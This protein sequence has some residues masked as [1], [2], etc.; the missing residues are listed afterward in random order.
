MIIT[1]TTDFG[2]ADP[3]VGM[4]KGVILS[5]APNAQLVDVTH[6]IRSYDILEAALIIEGSYRYFPRG[7]V[8]VIVVDPGVG[9]ERRPMAAT[10]NGHIF[11]APDNGVLSLVLHTDPAT[12]L[13]PAYQITNNSLFHG[14]VSRTF[15]GR[16]IFAPVAAHLAR[17]TPV[18]SVGPRIVDF[19]KKQIPLPRPQGDRL[20][21]TVLRIDKFGNIVTNFRRENLG[22]EF[23]IRIAGLSIT[24]LCGSFSE[25]DPGDFVAIEGSTGFI[26]LALNQGSAAERLGVER[27]AEIE[28]ETGSPNQ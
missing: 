21:G 28:L 6:E 12:S 17:G 5:I 15:H 10:A 13:T 27:G 25:A 16:D 26:E 3:F 4:M 11:V 1:L 24:R 14:P 23:S 18:E 19:I 9:S 20:V 7:T 22:E 8:H 2:L